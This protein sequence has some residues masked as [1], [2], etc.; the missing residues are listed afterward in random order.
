MVEMLGVLAV[1]GILSI[2]AK[3]NNSDCYSGNWQDISGECR[4]G[5]STIDNEIGLDTISQQL[6]KNANGNISKEGKKLYCIPQ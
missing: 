1:I 2:T 5:I 3:E 4:T 6:C